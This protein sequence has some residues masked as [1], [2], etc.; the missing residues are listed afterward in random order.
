MFLAVFLPLL[1]CGEP[2]HGVRIERAEAIINLGADP[3][4]LDPSRATDVASARALL[5]LTRGLTILDRNGHPQP[6]LAESWQ[7][8]PDRLTYVFNLRHAK[9]SNGL[10]VQASDFVHA[11]TR[12][13]LD[14]AFGAEYA[15]HLFYIKGA[16]AYYK[17]PERGVQSV[18]VEALGPRRL[19][20]TL[21]HPTPFFLHLVAHHSYFPVCRSLDRQNPS[22]PEHASSY[23]G[24]GPFLLKQYIPDHQLTVEKNPTYWNAERVRMERVVL[25]MIPRATTALIAMRNGEIDATANVPRAEMPLLRDDPMLRY[26]P[27]YATYYLNLNT[28]KPP[29][30]DPRVRRALALAI[31]RRAIVDHLT[32]AGEQPAFMLTPP[33]LY[34][35]PPAPAFPDAAFDAARGLLAEAGHP[36]GKGLRRLKYIYNTDEGH[37]QIAQVLQET[38]RKQLGIHISIE[39]QEFKVTINN[40]RLGNFDLARAGWVADFPDPINFLEIFDSDSNNNDSHWTDPHYDDLLAQARAQSDPAR[41]E[42][43][44]RRAE[45]RLIDQMV[46]VPIYFY[47]APYLVSPRLKGFDLNPVGMFDPARLA[48]STPSESGAPRPSAPASA[49]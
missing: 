30:D 29:L 39:N 44:L 14:P 6:E 1:G 31:D 20:V 2:H 41:R 24:C 33:Q 35:H 10:P 5:F 25:R 43:L 4:S 28:R 34:D 32:R 16:E 22:W 21:E 11:W 19:K 3:R 48:W 45:Q 7:I 15:Y 27:Q 13:M 37:R 47:T 38:W 42:D 17:N 12:R 8:R 40:R 49:E 9:W 18:G 26:S 36:G 46:I 23:V